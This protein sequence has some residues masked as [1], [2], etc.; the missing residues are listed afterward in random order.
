M[1]D[2]A[3]KIAGLI[4][5]SKKTCV[6]T[7]AGIS[8]ESGIPDFRSPGSGLWNR[9]DPMELL[10]TDALYSNPALF[11]GEGIKIL[12]PMM[13]AAPNAAHRILADMET[14][15]YIGCVITQ[16]IDDLHYKAGS[17]NIYE[18]HGNLRT[19]RC[20]SCGGEVG[21]ASVVEKAA[22]GQIPPRC[23]SC[24]GVLRTNVVLFGDR[25]PPCFSEAYYEARSSDLMIVIGSS[26]QVAPVNMLPSLCEKVAI[27]NLG[28]TPQDYR[29]A[30]IYREKASIALKNINRELLTA[31]VEK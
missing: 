18:V 13:D 17:K 25:L 19:G 8:T 24:G 29:A 12:K 4:L 11:Y 1:T 2:E 28:E 10:S 21:F 30:A 14:N 27:I 7:G 15:G 3:R 6:L 16:N 20:L 9:Y 31:D 26:L 23:D 5:G 22:S